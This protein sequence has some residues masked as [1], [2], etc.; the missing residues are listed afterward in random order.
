[1]ADMFCLTY[2]STYNI[3]CKVLFPLMEEIRNLPDNNNDE[4]VKHIKTLFLGRPALDQEKISEVMDRINKVF[5]DKLTQKGVLRTTFGSNHE[6]F[7]H[8]MWE[9]KAVVVNFVED[10]QATHDSKHG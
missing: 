7:I 4:W 6:E 10:W 5:I 3:M 8:T 2:N 9:Y 1:M